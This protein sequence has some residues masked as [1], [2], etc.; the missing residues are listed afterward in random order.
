MIQPQLPEAL[1]WKW[2]T[3]KRI[4]LKPRLMKGFITLVEAIVLVS[5]VVVLFLGSVR[6]AS[7]PIITIQCVWLVCLLWC[8]YLVLASSNPAILAIILAIGL[9]VDDA[10]VVAENYYRHIEEGET[11]FNAAIKGCR[12]SR[13]SCDCDDADFSDLFTCQLVWWLAWPPICSGSSR[14][15]LQQ[16]WSSLDLWH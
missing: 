1:R 12:R 8:I 7:I 4:S 15:R 13:L 5:A 16:R 6:V 14:S 10:I 2:F 3:T 11:P 9:V